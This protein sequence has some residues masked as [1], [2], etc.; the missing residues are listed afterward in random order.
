MAIQI[1]SF[2][3]I[4]GDMIRKII[5][6]TALNDVNAGSVLLTLLE[7]AAANDF[8][9]N[10]AILNVL[11]LLNIDAIKN[12]DLDAKAGDFGLARRPAVKASGLVNILNTNITKRSTGL[13]VIKPAPIA[14]QTKIY[15]NNTTGWA[16]TGNLYIGRGTD[17]F[18][19]PIAYTNITVSPTFS[20][21]TLASALQKDHLLSDSVI[22]SQGEPDRLIA[23]GTV[24]KIP[25]NNQNPEVQYV[26]LRDAVIPSGE[27]IVRDVQVIALV[28]GTAGNAGINTITSFDVAPFSGAA[29][30]NT[31]AFSNGKDIETDVELRNRLKSYAITLA[32]GTAPSIIA[33]V[34]GVSDP[35]DSNQVAS[36]VITEPVKVGDPSI[37]YIDDGSGFQPSFAG[38]SVDKLLNN[39]TGTEEF[40]QLANYPVPRPQVVNVEEGPFTLKDGSFIRVIVDGQEETIFFSSSQFLNI[41]AATM[42][43]V[44][45][46]INSKSE[47]FKARF[48][49][50]STGILLYPVAHDAEAIQVAPLRSSDDVTFYANNIL[51]FPTDEFSYIALYQNSE[52]LHEKAKSATLITTAFAQW[53]ITVTSNIIIAVDGTPAQDRSFALSDFPGASS[54]ASLT[55]QD[56]VDAVNA[57]FAGLTAVA[58]PSQTMVITSNKT[59]ASSSLVISGGTLLNK[60]FPNLPIESS[61]QTAQFELNRQTG[62]LRILTDVAIGDNFSAGVE[63]AKG[64]VISSATPNGTYNFSSDAFG[65]PADMIVVI[66]ATFCNQL[67]L[68]LLVGSTISITN[69][70][71]STM[72]IMADTATAFAA[73]KPGDYIYIAPRNA[74]WVSAANAGMFKIKAKGNHTTAS[75]DTFV[76]V[77]NVGVVVE[78]GKVIADS[79]DIKGFETDGFPQMWRGSYLSNPPA[80]AISDVV[81]SLNKD[82]AGI[83]ATIYKS[84]SIKITSTTENGG[85]IAIPVSISNASVVFGETESA[86]FGNVPHVAT[87]TSDKPLVG[88]FKRTDAVGQ[89]V[90]LGRHTYT[91]IK[92][93]LSSDSIPDSPPF[94][95]TYSENL[96]SSG[97]LTPANVDFDDYV[98]GTRG[99]NRGQFRS[100]K[101]E[102]ATDRVGTQQGVART[103]LDWVTG[104]E[105]ELVRPVNISSEDSVV[106]VMDKDATIKTVDVKMARTGR[107]NSGSSPGSFSPTTTEFSA[108]DQDNE[109]G[110][111]F[112]N[113]NVWGKV[114]NGTE[115]ADYAV[116]MRARN[117][118]ATGGV[119][120]SGGKMLVRSQQ[121][122]PN[123]EKLRFALAYPTSADQA[124]TSTFLNTPSWSLYKFFFGSGPA[125][126]TA[127]SAGYT[128]AVQGPYPDAAT[129]FPNGATSSGNY[130][131]YTFSAGNLAPVN[132]GDVLSI[133]SG[134]GISLANSGQFRVENKSGFTVR[135]INPSA[136]PTSPGSQ[137]VATITTVADVVGTPTVYTATTVA[138]V[139]GSLHLTYF[140]IHDAQGSVAV[141]FDVDNTGAPPPPH[142]ANRA[143]RVA[144][145]VTNDTANTVATKIGQVVALDSAYTVGVIGNQVTITNVVNGN[146]PAATAGTSGFTM[147]TTAGTADNSLDGKYFIIHD[148][149]GSVAVWYDVGDNGTPEPFHGADRSIRV[150]G[151]NAGDSATTV[152]AATVAVVNPDAFFT[153]SNV[154]NVVTITNVTAGNVPGPL[155]GTSGFSVGGT[156][157]SF[158]APE[159]ITNAGNIVFFPLT[160]NSVSAIATAINAGTI[161]AISPV[162]NPALTIDR[163]TDQEYYVYGGNSTALGYGHNP[164]VPADRD[165]IKLWDGVNWIKSFQNSNPNFTMKAVFTLN[166][167]APSVYQMDTAPNHDIPD[168]G[169]Q[170]KLIPVSVKNVHHH[171]TQ[172]ALSQLPIVANVRIGQDRKNVQITSKQLGSAGAIEMI[173]GN[174]NKAQAYIIGE[175][176]VPSDVSG[177]HLLVKIPAFPDT[178]N[179]SDYV[180]LENDAGV[181]RFSR[182]ISSDSIDVTNP[183]ANI[184]EYNYNPKVTNIVSGTTFAITDVSGSY[185]RPAG[186]V[187]RWT[188]SGGAVTLSNVRAGDAVF[189]FGNSLAWPQGNKV[190][191]AGDGKVA[192]LPIIAVNDGSNYFDVLNPYGKAQA[193]TAVGVGNTVQICPT[194]II[195]WNLAHAN[196][197]GITAISRTSN[198]VTVIASD[199][200]FMNSGDTVN[201]VDSNNVPDGSYG[202]ITVT[203]GNQFTFS[204]VGADF[205]EAAVG[206]TLIKDGVVPTRYRIEKLGFNDMVR[207]S[208][209]D[210]QSPRF[211]DSGVAVDDYVLLSGSTFKANNNGRFR[212]LAVDNDSFIIQNKS[213]SDE[214]NTVVPFNNKGFVATWTANTN[215]VTGVAGTFK[216]LNVGDWVKKPEDPDSLYRQ[217]VAFSPSTP[218]LATQITLGGNYGGSTALSGGVSYDMLN[219]YDKG[220]YLQGQD[221]LSFLEGDSAATADT[222]FVQNIVSANWFSVN[223]IGSFTLTEVGTNAITFKPFIR[224]NNPAGVA[225]ANRLMS[226]DV[227]GF[228]LIE[229]LAN[230]FSTIRKITN[231]ALDDLNFQRRAIYMSPPNRSHKF[232]DANKTSI[233][234]MGKLGYSTD[235]T[236]GIDGYL[237]YTGLLRRVQRIVD[238][239]EPDAENFPGRRAVGGSIET[240]PPLVRKISIS[241]N[242]TTD[243]GVNLGDI[244]NNIKSV[245]INYVQTLGV[246]EDV[247][248]SEIIAAIMNIKGVGAV[249]F[250]NPTPDTER[251]TIAN[252]EKAT[253]APEDI[254]IA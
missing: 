183:S 49:N 100:I 167:V 60:W 143:I 152:A 207:I 128:I 203:N 229:S 31:S 193:A 190:R 84:N 246:G 44:I 228:F 92:G 209:Q 247:I 113:V 56:W 3:Q 192:G 208:R 67:S 64:F 81:N 166:G 225:E 179:I 114:I 240:L 69:P 200:H 5:A 168:L 26:T 140:I 210:G 142:G 161:I 159:L 18:E 15:V 88:M 134:S 237:Y 107:V 52:R 54:F 24:V 93:P 59:G 42:A 150:P 43:E 11:E 217:V 172:K 123:G 17:S 80:A 243:E 99:G 112:N 33:S 23:A 178:F 77:D 50:Q 83:L 232:S 153:A 234:H 7:A 20:E 90:F 116:W 19:G 199:A 87:R 57:K 242:V 148:E 219:D 223:N 76:D 189:A 174:A 39:A 241:I 98:A 216:N 244:S 29:V 202:P 91:D 4:L 125:R 227:A 45:V 252:N 211:T 122:G 70:S 215:L 46:A 96:H 201:I 239:Y 146:F 71:S 230:K 101:A 126:A 62:N 1:K 187:W 104:N 235:I 85:S 55:I 48:A 68:P 226:V 14:G 32:R 156:S 51:K 89:N 65:R 13:Y 173:G 139:A 8:E 151:V 82:M 58:T 170:F 155:A 34:I 63:D 12:N 185:G 129:N 131:D 35:D 231:I 181:K 132:I 171:L 145:V 61:G 221:D 136:S 165:H 149:N 218:A 191:A 95:G 197:V 135:L 41:S 102:I 224:V 53:N 94:S 177:E 119:A 9:N 137:E 47:S 154:G 25:A 220:V 105:I 72:R 37:L 106:I 236:T 118:Y 253:I 120:G 158:P 245:V 22:D 175:S 111:D 205:T 103:E 73:L 163:S 212:V 117:W 164:N 124:A 180:K 176:S 138:D 186:F 188:H 74:A 213:A 38:Q 97:V 6:D 182:L 133:S 121:F 169:E 195:K 198:V 78:A 110:I 233:T 10:T 160:G 30:T 27:D 36:A 108:N 127:L 79:L 28:A 184:I 130:Y 206:A 21:I 254:G 147:G 16:P 204:L 40:L 249:T 66:D 251:I 214:I 157:G 196:R 141:W 86:Q 222:L 115:F 144:T 194:P 162:G 250:T 109:P 75:V 2:N 238:G 248:L